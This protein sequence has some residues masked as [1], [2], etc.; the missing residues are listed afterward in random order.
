MKLLIDMNLSPRWVDVLAAAG[1]QA[2]HWSGL[3]PRDAPDEAI[4]T[5]ARADSWVVLTNDLDF[6]LSLAI[7]LDHGPS[8]VQ[9]RSRHTNP[10]LLGRDVVRAIVSVAPA[11]E[12]GALFTIEPGRSRVRLLPFHWPLAPE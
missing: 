6:S 4:L 10:D 12:R 1:L 9:V 11:L 8:V 5:F 7:S 2:A 3:G